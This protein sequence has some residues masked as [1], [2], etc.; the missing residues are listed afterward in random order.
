MSAN[1]HVLT[2]TLQFY[3]ILFYVG[4]CRNNG[5]NDTYMENISSS[6]CMWTLMGTLMGVLNPKSQLI[7]SSN[8]RSQLTKIPVSFLTLPFHS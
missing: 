2:I 1:E 7:V 3:F 8:P 4:P 5:V 6:T